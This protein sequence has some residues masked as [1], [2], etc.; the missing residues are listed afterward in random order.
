MNIEDSPFLS[1]VHQIFTAEPYVVHPQIIMSPGWMSHLG[2]QA[3][4]FGHDTTELSGTS[5]VYYL[6]LTVLKVF[7][8]CCNSLLLQPTKVFILIIR[9]HSEQQMA[10]WCHITWIYHSN[11]PEFY[12]FI[13]W[14]GRWG[15]GCMCESFSLSNI[16]LII[17]DVAILKLKTYNCIIRNWPWN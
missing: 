5:S 12:L 14:G 4:R 16:N 8:G 10:D 2:Q 11:F 17:N 7:P 13:Y 1:K 3:F 15:E 9:N 6:T